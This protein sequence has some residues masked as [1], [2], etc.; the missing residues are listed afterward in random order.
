MTPDSRRLRDVLSKC[1]EDVDGD[2][3]VLSGDIHIMTRN[4]TFGIML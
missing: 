1:I 3:F 4:G 2:V